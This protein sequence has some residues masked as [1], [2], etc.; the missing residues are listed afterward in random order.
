MLGLN[1][2]KWLSIWTSTVG[3][4]IRAHSRRADSARNANR[5]HARRRVQRDSWGSPLS[6]V[7]P[8]ASRT[9]QPALAC[10]GEEQ[11]AAAKK[12]Y[13][14][15]DTALL[16]GSVLAILAIWTKLVHAKAQQVIKQIWISPHFGVLSRYPCAA[17]NLFPFIRPGVL[18]P[19]SAVKRLLTIFQ[20]AATRAPALAGVGSEWRLDKT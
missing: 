15:Q 4:N 9:Y 8:A 14:I 2:I 5:S 6:F 10:Q 3:T 19:H 18:P 11:E 12:D 17:D 1:I 7:K 16:R 13:P 20:L